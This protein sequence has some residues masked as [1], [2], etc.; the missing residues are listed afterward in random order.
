MT[1]VWLI[2]Y[3]VSIVNHHYHPA[4]ELNGIMLL[5]AGYFFATGIREQSS[6]R[7]HDNAREEDE[8]VRHMIEDELERH[9]RREHKG[10]GAA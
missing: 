6:E 4:P 10:K 2:S 1:L 9:D 5:V 8:R 7:K 3:A